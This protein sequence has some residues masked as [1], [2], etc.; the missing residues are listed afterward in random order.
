M[1]TVLNVKRDWSYGSAGISTTQRTATQR[2]TVLFDVPGDDLEYYARTA[3]GVPQ[4]GSGYGADSWLVVTE[5][6]AEPR[7]SLIL[8]DVYVTYETVRSAGYRTGIVEAGESPISTLP[9][10]RWTSQE[11]E[12]E[13]QADINGNAIVNTNG[14]LIQGLTKPIKDPMLIVARNIYSLDPAL[15]V[16]YTAEGGATNSDS[17]LGF[18]PGQA[19]LTK[20]EASQLYYGNNAYVH[21]EYNVVFRRGPYVEGTLVPAKAW[22]KRH[23]NRGYKV[24]NGDGDEWRAQSNMADDFVSI[25]DPSPEPVLLY[26]DGQRIPRGS[27]SQTYWLFTQVFPSLPFAPL[28]IL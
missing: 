11:S 9:D 23:A 22:Y 13:I 20:F 7:D 24:V 2:Y 26:A 21:V 3:S 17:F 6:R 10:I 15:I 18:L 19:W 1:S 25:A 27:E 16:Q 4:M 28:G 8:Y 12:E 14:E 5:V